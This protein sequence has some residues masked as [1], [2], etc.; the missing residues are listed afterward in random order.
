MKY[1]VLAGALALTLCAGLCEAEDLKTTTASKQDASSRAA[2]NYSTKSRRIDLGDSSGEPVSH[3]GVMS[4]GK[5]YDGNTG[6]PNIVNS[7]ADM[8]LGS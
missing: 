3:I 4:P 8:N 7:D 2:C 6:F 5:N 1:T